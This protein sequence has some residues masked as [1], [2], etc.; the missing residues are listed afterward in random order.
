MALEILAG[1]I[2]VTGWYVAFVRYNRRRAAEVLLWIRTAFSG[3]AQILGVHWSSPSRFRIKLRV[4]PSVFHD[5]HVEV[6]LVPRE[7]F[8]NWLL[9]KIRKQR[10]IAIFEADLDSAPLFNL[11][12]H[13]QRWCG[14][15]RRGAKLHPRGSTVETFGPMVITTRYDWQREITAMI[16]TLVASRDSD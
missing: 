16:D 6:R 10:E 11:E 1:L 3:H 7:F 8:L 2:L 14:R 4:V 5:S 13:N 12:V 15:S 9:C